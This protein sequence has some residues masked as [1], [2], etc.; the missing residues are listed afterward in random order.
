MLPVSF[1][2]S[3]ELREFHLQ[4]RLCIRIPYTAPDGDEVAVRFRLALERASDGPDRRFRWKS[5]AKP[6]LYGLWGLDAAR[7]AGRVLLV[8][9]ESDVQ[10]VLYHDLPALGLPGAGS[11]NEDRDAEHLDGIGVIYA[12]IEPDRGG[13]AMLDKLGASRIAERLRVVFMPRETKD[14]SALHLADPGRFRE[15]IDALL[16]GA[17]PYAERAA[18]EAAAARD[19]AWSSCQHLVE[20]SDVLELLTRDVHRA[21]LVGE[22]R[23]VKLLFLAVV[24]RLLDR[25]VSVAVKGPSAGGKSYLVETVL[26]FFDSSAAYQL[27]AMSERAL[28]YSTEPLKHRML[29][30]YEAAGMESEFA[31]YLIRSL[32]S[33]G[34]VR[35]ETVEKTANG[36]EA[37]LIERAG[38]TGLITTTTRLALH[39]ENETRMLSIPVSD[40]S[41]QTRAVFLSLATE[42][43]DPVDRAP[44]HALGVWLAGAEHR[45]AIPFAREL[46]EAVPPVAVRLRRDFRVILTLIRAHA[47]LH[48]ATRARDETGRVVASID[49]YSVIRGLVQDLMSEAVEQTVSPT[50]RETVHAVH[51]LMDESGSGHATIRQVAEALRLDRSAATRRVNAAIRAGWLVNE[52]EQ[53]GKTRAKRLIIGAQLPEDVPLLPEPASLCTCAS[54]PVGVGDTPPPRPEDLDRWE[55]AAGGEA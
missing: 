47:L 17:V 39:P 49:D 46:A 50:V 53:D 31:T 15:R 21:G 16:A 12:L 35:Y 37:R 42:E 29:V 22:E 25:P 48:Q 30:I 10:T 36:L 8:E 26:S 3:L 2:E 24:S 54:D 13:K 44:W 34:C 33:E 43:A 20:A 27:S 14:A 5:G 9:G 11:W 28:A 41:A 51:K 55:Q 1:L 38:P 32:L 45:V 7:R 18:A 52:G 6:L 40:T 23:A 19:A 4:G